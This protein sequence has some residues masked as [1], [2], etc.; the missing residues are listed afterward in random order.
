MDEIDDF[1]RQ[2][3]ALLQID[4]RQ[5]GDALAEQVGLSPASCLRRLQR[6]RRI[7]AVEREVAIVA[8]ELLGRHITVL[9]LLTLRRGGR[10]ALDR[11][12]QKLL[13]LPQV[14]RIFHVTGPADFVLTVRCASMEAYA[15]FT[16]EHFY[17]PAISGFESIVVLREHRPAMPDAAH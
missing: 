10:D 11:L 15:A 6:L 17:D 16:E 1:D 7:G 12:R 13:R 8:P 9:S 4:C 5:T 3:L 14:E 2:L